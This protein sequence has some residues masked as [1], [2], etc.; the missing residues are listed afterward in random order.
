MVGFEE[1]SVEEWLVKIV[2]SLYSIRSRLSVKSFVVYH[3]AG[4]II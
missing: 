1:P 2:Q 3:S 4:G